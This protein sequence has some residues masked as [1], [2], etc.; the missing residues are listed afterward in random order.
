MLLRWATFL[1]LD[2]WCT[3]G[4]PNCNGSIWVNLEACPWEEIDIG[5][6]VCACSKV[7]LQ[8]ETTIFRNL[9]ILVVHVL[10][11]YIDLDQ[12]GNEAT[13]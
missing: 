4:P 8:E 12:L 10:E 7:H 2:I 6:L 9:L 11:V 3:Y 13:P 5:R 1:A